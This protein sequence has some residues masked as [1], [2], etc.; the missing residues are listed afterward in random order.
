MS[1]YRSRQLADQKL[2]A[3]ERRRKAAMWAQTGS[4][5][6]VPAKPLELRRPVRD[7]TLLAHAPAVREALAGR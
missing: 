2:I 7:E 3:E 5:R 1:Y 6:R 4:I